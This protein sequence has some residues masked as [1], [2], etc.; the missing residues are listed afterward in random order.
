MRDSIVRS[1]ATNRMKCQK[2]LVLAMNEHDEG[3][4]EN[5]KVQLSKISSTVLL[6]TSKKLP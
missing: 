6:A 2:P 1:A 5:T 3:S 4:S